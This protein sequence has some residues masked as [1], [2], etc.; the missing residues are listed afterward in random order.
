MKTDKNKTVLIILIISAA[1]LIAGIF[2]YRNL[3]E[4]TNTGIPAVK[5]LKNKGIKLTRYQKFKK[6]WHKMYGN[7]RKEKVVYSFKTS[8]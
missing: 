2:L 1:V 8:L 6:F 7:L 3:N 4:K 5:S